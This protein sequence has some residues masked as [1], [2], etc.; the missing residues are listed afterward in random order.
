MVMP[1]PAMPDEI[2][3]PGAQRIGRQLAGVD[4]VGERADLLQHF[5]LGV[6]ALGQ[7]AGV[8]RQRV[9]AARLGK[10]LDQ[11]F[12][13]RVEKQHAQIDLPPAQ[14]SQSRRADP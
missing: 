9:A 5:A 1:V 13:L 6:D 2:L 11:R 12:G 14:V 3:D 4:A 8:V 10:A 7:G